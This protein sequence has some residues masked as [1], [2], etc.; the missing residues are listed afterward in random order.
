LNIH[1]ALSPTVTVDQKPIFGVPVAWMDQPAAFD[2]L[3]QRLA[4]RKFTRVGFLNAHI[5]NMA[6]SDAE[7]A[8]MMH[9]FLVLPD[10]VGVDIAA[11]IFYGQP[12]PANLNGTDL[13]PALLDTVEQPLTV[14]LVGTTE[15]NAERAVSELRRRFPRHRFVLISHGYFS[16][17]EEPQILDR[18]KGLRPDMLLVS[19]GVP[20]QEYWIWKNIRPEH[21]TMSFAVGALMDFLSGSVPRAPK[22]IRS[23]RLEWLY[24]LY[25]E[26]RRLWRRYVVGN[27]LFLYRVLRERLAGTGR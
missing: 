11:T 22:W 17:T 1:S 3:Q 9:D 26:P 6:K 7:F 23:V 21:A 16:Q 15:L 24:R 14:A 18:L 19:L 20:R 4:D 8:D 10:G 5:A 12:F 13:V 25:V 27:P 2:L